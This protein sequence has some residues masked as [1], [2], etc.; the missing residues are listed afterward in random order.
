[1]V[2]EDLKP[3]MHIVNNSLIKLIN[4]SNLSYFVFEIYIQYIYIS[5]LTAKQNF[6]I[7]NDYVQYL[8]SNKVTE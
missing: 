2:F 1:M 4:V 5:Y 7:A 6:T 3:T 8:V